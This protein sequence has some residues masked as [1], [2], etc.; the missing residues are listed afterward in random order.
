MFPIPPPLNVNRLRVLLAVAMSALLLVAV[1]PAR[2]TAVLDTMAQ[3]MKACTVCHGA[4]GRATAQG[5][6]PRIAGKPAGYLFEQLRAFRDGRRS[7]QTMNEFVAHMSD[8]YLREIAEYFAGLELPYPPPQT[9]GAVPAVLAQGQSLVL[10]GDVARGLPACS[11]C[12]GEAMTGVLPA[13]PGL[14][15]LPRDYLVAQ[16]GAWRTGLRKAVE[17]DC[18]A[19]IARRLSEAEIAALATWLSAQ[20]V[21]GAGKPAPALVGPRPPL[22]CGSGWR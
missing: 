1:T 11:A 18:M 9:R 3:R 19:T 17:P 5:Y 15:G 22:D 12:H 13:V 20:P 4:E 8:D 10:R 16:L 7:Q 6:F 2:A 14:L 21:P